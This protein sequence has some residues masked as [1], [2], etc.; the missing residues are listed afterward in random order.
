[1]VQSPE[2]RGVFFFVFDA[3]F[4]QKFRMSSRRIEQGGLGAALFVFCSEHGDRGVDRDAGDPRGELGAGVEAREPADDAEEGLLGGVGGKV[5]A[6]LHDAE[7]EGVDAVLP[8]EAERGERV[9]VA[10]DEFLE[11]RVVWM[12]TGRRGHAWCDRTVCRRYRTVGCRCV[13]AGVCGGG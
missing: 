13:F 9:G 10:R 6:V 8:V 7:G 5:G 11:R 2:E 12:L 4:G 3:G 1:M